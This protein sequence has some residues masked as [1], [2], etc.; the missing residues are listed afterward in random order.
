MVCVKVGALINE[1]Y[2]TSSSTFKYYLTPLGNGLS[3]G[4][5]IC[6]DSV[7]LAEALFAPYKGLA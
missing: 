4:E 3:M 1:H 7:I 6:I 2:T 5:M